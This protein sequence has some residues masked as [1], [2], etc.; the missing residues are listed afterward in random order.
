MKGLG[1]W[2]AIAVTSAPVY[3]QVAAFPPAAAPASPSGGSSIRA[4]GGVSLDRK[5]LQELINVKDPC[6]NAPPTPVPPQGPSN[7]AQ[8]PPLTTQWR[9]CFPA[10]GGRTVDPQIAVSPTRVVVTSQARLGFYEKSGSYLGSITARQMFAPLGL[11][12]GSVDAVNLY[13]DLRAIY[14]GYRGRFWLQATGFTRSQPDPGKRK[15]ITAVAV[16]KSQSPLDGWYLYW[17]DAVNDFGNP[18]G[19]VY[20]A[21]DLAEEPFL[22][23]DPI[24]IQQ[25]NG[26]FN[27]GNHRYW[28][29]AFFP[30]AAMAAGTPGPL[31]GWQYGD[32][33]NPNGGAA[34][35]VQP[36]VH[37]G[38]TTRAYYTSRQGTSQAVVWAVSNPFQPGQQL[39]RVAVTMPSAWNTPVNAPQAG[40]P[41]IIRMNRLGTSVLKADYRNG[42]LHLVTNDAKNWFGDGMLSSIRLVRM[43]VTGYP[44]IPTSGGFINRVVGQNDGIDDPSDAHIHYAWPAVAVN[45]SGHMVTV[46]SRSGAGLFPEARYSAYFSNESDM[47]ASRVLKAGEAPYAIP[48][49]SGLLPWGETAG[50]SVDPYDDKAVWMTHQY[51]SADPGAL[52]NHDLWVGKVLGGQVI[53]IFVQAIRESDPPEGGPGMPVD[54]VYQLRNEGDGLAESI[55]VEVF[56]VGEDGR[57]VLLSATEQKGLEPGTETLVRETVVIPRDTAPGHYQIRIVADPANRNPE[58]SEDNNA[59]DVPLLVTEAR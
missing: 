2:V 54:I 14:D 26:V 49:L 12:D 20:Q 13:R 31:A 19:S 46:F 43:D 34:W 22:G 16:S 50:A 53:D 24:A 8:T 56:L 45:A 44:F 36:V 15:T 4:Y 6:W 21:G 57:R 40:S 37:H 27:S 59:A 32:L 28:R 18:A 9:P 55:P 5:E 48:G 38:A 30:A 25:A 29:I 3:A 47:R 7:P 23:I 41:D 33:K 42:W 11:D 52:G 1:L 35:M 58:Y 10:Q 51:S 17:W 39:T